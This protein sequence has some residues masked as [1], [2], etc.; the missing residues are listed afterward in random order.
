[1]NVSHFLLACV[2][3][4]SYGSFQA[5]AVPAVGPKAV[6]SSNTPASATHSTTHRASSS[7]NLL[8]PDLCTRTTVTLIAT[9]VSV[10]T[11][12]HTVT[13]RVIVPTRMAHDKREV[14]INYKSS[15]KAHSTMATS[16]TKHKS[17]T[18]PDLVITRR[19]DEREEDNRCFT[20]GIVPATLG[21]KKTS[22]FS[23]ANTKRSSKT[24]PII[25][26]TPT[27]TTTSSAL[28]HSIH[29]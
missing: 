26:A 8:R 5:Q 17:S 3:L 23:S 15:S 29:F 7:T 27:P 20:V 11:K 2:V 9:E 6:S 18:G 14:C 12:T 10:T 13:E 28:I 24:K 1:M 21:I 25:K 4:L 22:T 16:T 19:F